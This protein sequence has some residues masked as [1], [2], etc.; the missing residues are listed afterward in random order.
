MRQKL[1]ARIN[2]PVKRFERAVS[3]M[4]RRLKRFNWGATRKWAR[5]ELV[6]ETY[7]PGARGQWHRWYK[8]DQ[9][10]KRQLRA[11][12]QTGYHNIHPDAWNLKREMVP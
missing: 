7:R 3:A 4:L 9:K 11:L 6:R 8:A 2:A 1:L 10:R 12:N 5:E